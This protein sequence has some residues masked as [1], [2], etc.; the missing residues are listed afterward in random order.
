MRARY[1]G[2]RDR[3]LA[4]LAE[5]APGLVPVGISAGLGVLIELPGSGPTAAQLVAEA[6]DRSIELHAL[7]PHYRDGDGPRDGVLIGYGAIPEHD[8]TAALSALGALLATT[9]DARG[10]DRC[11][12]SGRARRVRRG[13]PR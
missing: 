8:F 2:R 7:A 13:R 3:V 12:P 10:R 6:A 11:R 4:M 9:T 5:R 1:R